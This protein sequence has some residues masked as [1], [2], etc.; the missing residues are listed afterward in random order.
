MAQFDVLLIQNVHAS[1]IEYQ[2]KFVNIAKGGLLSANVLNVPTILPAGTNGY[3]LQRD[4]VELTGLKWVDPSTF[5][6]SNITVTNQGDNRV[7]TATTVTNTLNAESGLTYDGTNLSVTGNVLS[8][9]IKELTPTT[10]V[11]IQSVL[12]L[13]GIGSIVTSYVLYYNT[14][15]KVVTYGAVQSGVIPVDSTLLDWSTNKYQPYAVAAAGAFDTSATTPSGTTRLNYGGYFYATQLYEGASRVSIITHTHGDI[16]SG[17]TI[18]TAAITPASGDYIVLTDT[19]ASGLVSRGIALGTGTTTYLRNDGTWATPM[20]YPGNG[21]AVSNGSTWGTSIIP[22]MGFLRYTG[23]AYQWVNETYL[24]DTGGNAYL[25]ANPYHFY[26]DVVSETYVEC[27]RVSAN[28][29]GTGGQVTLYVENGNGSIIPEDDHAIGIIVISGETKTHNTGMYI[30]GGFTSDIKE[31][32]GIQISAFNNGTGGC[33]AL[34]ITNGDVFMDLASATT[35]YVIYFDVT[36]KLL[37]YGAAPGGSGINYWAKSGT[38][39]SPVTA[40]DDM[41]L[42]NGDKISWNDG[43]TYITGSYSGMQYLDFF[44]SSTKIFWISSDAVWVHDQVKLTD[45]G[46]SPWTLSNTTGNITATHSINTGGTG[47]SLTWSGGGSSSVT[48]SHYGGNL[49]LKGGDQTGSGGGHGGD[50]YIYG[51]S[52]ISSAR[53]NIYFGDSSYGYLPAK[54]SE[55]NVVY[56]DTATGKL[57]Y[58]VPSGGTIN[59]SGASNRIAYW[60]DADTLTSS[61]NLVFDGNN[62][63]IAQGIIL[64]APG[65]TQTA[66]GIKTTLTAGEALAFGNMVYMK[67]D[68]KVWKASASA[69][70]TTPVIGM[71]L[72]SVSANGSA[73]ILLSGRAYNSS[74]SLGTGGDEIYLTTSAGG[75]STSAPSGVTGYVVQVL[76]VVLSAT[77]IYFNP[78]LNQTVLT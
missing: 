74:W 77:T 13:S 22:A 12:K 6:G 34:K 58:G 37:T 46:A 20:I 49:I 11:D 42:P 44:I 64:S 8:N 10:G 73:T 31:M 27:L 72:N 7:V 66:S 47:Y 75:F 17:G 15:T 41:L 63:T 53:G 28:N 43:N 9:I 35:G 19:S 78:S 70:T 68:G 76:G 26:R 67:N 59:G 33:T 65:T 62:L 21:I 5:G 69:L 61:A 56:Y 71:C 54:G 23:S 4:D 25:T 57:S 30:G 1:G 38:N 40:G 24:R 50:V 52:S 45:S 32:I 39:L 2:E 3:I 36:T 51:G 16:T 55:T 60:S 29:T 18:S 14:T 48:A